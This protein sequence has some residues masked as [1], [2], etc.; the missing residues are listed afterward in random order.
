MSLM[1]Y[2]KIYF[3]EFKLNVIEALANY[4]G[5]YIGQKDI[6]MYMFLIRIHILK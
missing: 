2:F 4:S 1:S 3:S 6:L 5:L